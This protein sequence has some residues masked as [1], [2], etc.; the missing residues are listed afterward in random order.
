M[1]EEKEEKRVVARGR[2]GERIEDKCLMQVYL[3]LNLSYRT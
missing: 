3:P 2:S 1:E